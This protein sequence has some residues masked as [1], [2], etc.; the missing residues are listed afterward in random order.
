MGN[1]L[2]TPKHPE[3]VP[4]HLISPSPHPLIHIPRMPTPP[5]TRLRAAITLVAAAS[6]AALGACKRETASVEELYSTRMLGVS[7][8]QRNQLGEAEA[9]FQKLT[10]LAPEDPLGFA[11]L[12]FTY[13]Q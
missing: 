12:G 11:N 3:A 7:Y 2:A 1:D 8:L 4:R 6:L 13:L 5:S 9:Q 10:E